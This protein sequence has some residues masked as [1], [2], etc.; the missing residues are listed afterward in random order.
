MPHSRPERTF[1][2]FVLAI[3]NA[4]HLL[5]QFSISAETSKLSMSSALNACKALVSWQQLPCRSQGA[6][7]MYVLMH[8]VWIRWK[9]TPATSCIAASRQEQRLKSSGSMTFPKSADWCQKSPIYMHNTFSGII[10]NRSTVCCR[11][12]YYESVAQVE[13]NKCQTVNLNYINYAM[14]MMSQIE[15]SQ[16]YF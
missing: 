1:R 6:L 2:L 13:T 16:M 9:R 7:C 10:W 3:V 12:W 5:A 4:L 8:V 14:I 15:Y 11:I